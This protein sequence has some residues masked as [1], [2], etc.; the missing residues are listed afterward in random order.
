[1]NNTS[2]SQ[3]TNFTDQ[4]TKKKHIKHIF[5]M[6][7]GVIVSQLQFSEEQITL[8]ER[9]ND[10]NFFLNFELDTNYEQ[11]RFI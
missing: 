3:F 9:K 1:M 2:Y 7:I 8:N 5:F 4:S 11:I 6:K 10:S